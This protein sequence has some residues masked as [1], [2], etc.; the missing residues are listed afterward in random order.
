MYKPLMS[1]DAIAP[2]QVLKI[3]KCK[4]E[5]GCKRNKPT[6]CSCV[7]GGVSCDVL[8]ECAETCKNTDLLVGTIDTAEEEDL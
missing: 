8:C 4:C 1:L 7:K 5:T 3:S 6:R 2:E